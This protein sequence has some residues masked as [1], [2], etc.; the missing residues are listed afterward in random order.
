MAYGKKGNPAPNMSHAKASSL[1]GYKCLPISRS[2][3][4][5]SKGK[6]SSAHGTGAVGAT[7]SLHHAGMRIGHDCKG[8][9]SGP[10]S[11]KKID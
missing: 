9:K 5:R 2:P 6:M 4:T 3:S 1:P 7:K 8:F 10:V 11:P